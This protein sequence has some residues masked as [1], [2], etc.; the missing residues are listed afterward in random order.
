MSCWV[1][2][3]T[4]FTKS[5][6]LD[7]LGN[8]FNYMERQDLYIFIY[9]TVRFF[10]MFFNH[11]LRYQGVSSGS[12]KRSRARNGAA[13][14]AKTNSEV[15][16]PRPNI[17]GPTLTSTTRMEPTVNITPNPLGTSR[18]STGSANQEQPASQLRVA[19]KSTPPKPA[20]PEPPAVEKEERP[21]K[22]PPVQLRNR[23]W[24]PKGDKKASLNRASSPPSVTEPTRPVKPVKPPRPESH[25]GVLD[26]PPVPPHP[27][28]KGPREWPPNDKKNDASPGTAPGPNAP[29]SQLKVA[30]RPVPKGADAR[31]PK[32]PSEERPS[33]LPLKPSDIK[34]GLEAGNDRPISALNAAGVKKA[35]LKPPGPIPP[36]PGSKPT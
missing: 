25:A 32:R 26:K 29:G 2:I 34:K 6:I 10:D 7:R 4:N 24:P 3:Q 36:R 28:K 11:V 17:S 13:A 16:K 31:F 22:I 5:S 15:P 27:V 35:P 33:S 12:P 8:P 18:Y 1:Y 20:K 30:L 9:L 23:E 14:T 21:P 19:L